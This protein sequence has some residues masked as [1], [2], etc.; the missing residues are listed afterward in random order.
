MLTLLYSL[1]NLPIL[2]V[3]S[4]LLSVYGYLMYINSYWKRHGINYVTATPFIGNLKEVF[5]FRKNVAENF[6]DLYNEHTDEPIVGIHLFM[7]PALLI[8]NLELIK[9]IVIKDY[10]SFQNR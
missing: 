4:V 2:V 3:L 10:G 9:E 8:R 7:K 5:M 1:I 6:H